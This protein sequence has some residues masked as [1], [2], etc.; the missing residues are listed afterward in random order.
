MHQYGGIVE[1]F[2]KG[3]LS[4][5]RHGVR[6]DKKRGISFLLPDRTFCFYSME[7][8]VL[9]YKRWKATDSLDFCFF[10]GSY[11]SF[12]E[13][14]S[15]DGMPPVLSLLKGFKKY[16]FCSRLYLLNARQ[17]LLVYS[18]PR[19]ND[20]SPVFTVKLQVDKASFA[21]S[22]QRTLFFWYAF[23]EFLSQEYQKVIGKQ[24]EYSFV[25]QPSLLYA[26]EADFSFIQKKSWYTGGAPLSFKPFLEMLQKKIQQLK[27][28]YEGKNTMEEDKLIKQLT[29][30]K[31][32]SSCQRFKDAS[33]VVDGS[34]FV[35]A[36]SC[37]FRRHMPLCSCTKEAPCAQYESSVF[38]TIL[39]ALRRYPEKDLADI[40]LYTYRQ[41]SYDIKAFVS[42]AGIQKIVYVEDL[43]FDNADHQC[44][45]VRKAEKRE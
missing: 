31:E 10:Y 34:G 14:T 25:F 39:L 24:V 1:F 33:L 41:P 32:S 12:F 16:P 29:S 4:F 45:L 7:Q 23:G 5:S 36:E 13:E 15:P 21:P 26:T 2:R 3:L 18:G 30:L 9:P 42:H 28:K 44:M 6:G 22:L 37:S 20:A 19:E 8:E 43:G 38:K 17:R 11:S 40:T 35:L 27:K